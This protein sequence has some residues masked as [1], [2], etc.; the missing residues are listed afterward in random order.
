[1][2]KFNILLFYLL[3][4]IAL[5]KHINDAGLVILK[6]KNNLEIISAVFKIIILSGKSNKR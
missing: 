3:N 2:K 5:W 4:N 1:M 6:W